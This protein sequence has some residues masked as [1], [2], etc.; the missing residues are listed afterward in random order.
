MMMTAANIRGLA[1]HS[2]APRMEKDSLVATPPPPNC[3]LTAQTPRLRFLLTNLYQPLEMHGNTEGKSV[4]GSDAHTTD[5]A[6]RCVW[7]ESDAQCYRP[8]G[9][10]CRAVGNPSIIGGFQGAPR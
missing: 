10:N 5:R 4:P 8:L 6:W 9:K 2:Q 3:N 1:T 7:L